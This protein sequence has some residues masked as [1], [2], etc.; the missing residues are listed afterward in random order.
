MSP[1][2]PEESIPDACQA[3]N[4]T[5]ALEKRPGSQNIIPKPA[6]YEKMKKKVCIS[7]WVA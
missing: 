1:S 6:L 7:A 5:F 2:A 3:I 4:Y